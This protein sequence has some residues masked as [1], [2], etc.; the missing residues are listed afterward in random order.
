MIDIQY[1]FQK[2]LRPGGKYFF[3]KQVV[4]QNSGRLGCS[5]AMI[6]SSKGAQSE[7]Q[8]RLSVKLSVK[9]QLK[10]ADLGG[11]GYF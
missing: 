4:L 1:V 5:P 6:P 10:V 7:P 9:V 3:L 2:F 11:R 8:K